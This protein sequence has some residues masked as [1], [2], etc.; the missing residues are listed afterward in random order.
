MRVLINDLLSYSQTDESRKKIELI[1]LGTVLNEVIQDLKEEIQQK[2]ADLEIK[3]MCSVR[4]IPFQMAQL[5]YNIIGN[6]IK[7]SSDKR[8]L[9]I[10]ISSAIINGNQIKNPLAEDK[11][12]C[13]IA[14][15]DNGIGFG[16]QY[17]DKIFGLFQRLHP[18]SEY[19]GTGV[20]LAIVKKIVENHKGFMDAK[21]YP[22]KGAEFNIYL[23]VD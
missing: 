14:I 6:S 13:H 20:G 22:D 8:P 15:S 2:S 23:A 11:N 21:G 3:E 18:K 12:Y 7:Y 1:D 16:Q 5:F 9:K 10:N 4:A 19:A 17:N